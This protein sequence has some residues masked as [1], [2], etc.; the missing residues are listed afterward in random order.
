[1]AK[2]GPK[3]RGGE[4]VVVADA[5]PKRR[6]LQGLIGKVE[7]SMWLARYKTYKYLVAFNEHC[8]GSFHYNEL[9]PTIKR[10]YVREYGED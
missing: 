8:K 2:V 4:E 5:I 7:K 3:F 10:E 9:A 6:H 1:M